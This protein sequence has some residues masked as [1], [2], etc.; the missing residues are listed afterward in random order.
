MILLIR[1]K[2]IGKQ[3]KKLAAVPMVFEKTPGNMREL[4]TFTVENMV[5][6][7]NDRVRRGIGDA[8]LHA[9]SE[10]QLEAMADIGRISFGVIYQPKEQDAGLAVESAVMAYMD[11]MVRVF[12]NGELIDVPGEN[13][14]LKQEDLETYRLDLKEGDEIAFVRLTMLAGRMW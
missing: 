14:M 5:N 2:Q 8:S 1:Q 13:G 7:F 6:A 11:G 4:L 9:L 12:I 10:E 3:K